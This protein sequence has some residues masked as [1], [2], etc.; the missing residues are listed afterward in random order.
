MDTAIMAGMAIVVITMGGRSA[1]ATG[2]TVTEVAPG[3][4]LQ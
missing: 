4:G 1:A 3:D 2:D